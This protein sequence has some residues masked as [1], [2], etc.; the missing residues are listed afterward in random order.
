MRP[1]RV[2]TAAVLAGALVIPATAAS[3]G[4]PRD[5]ATGGGQILVSTE[6]GPGSTIA[7]TAQGSPEEA[8]GQIQFVDR[9]AGTGRDQVKAHYVVDCVAVEQAADT[10]ETAAYI[11]GV[12]R[13]DPTDVITMYVVDNGEGMMADMDIVAVMPMGDDESSEGPC[14]VIEPSMEERATYALARGNAQ[15]YDADAS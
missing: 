14:G 13:D 12:N 7:F 11:S 1:V 15:T 4:S 10:E 6:G 8:K 2:L 5:R 9:S 3:A